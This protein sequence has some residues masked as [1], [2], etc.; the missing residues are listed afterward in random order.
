MKRKI[1]LKYIGIVDDWQGRDAHHCC[2]GFSTGEREKIWAIG[3]VK[4]FFFP[5]TL[6]LAEAM[7]EG[8]YDRGKVL[9]AGMGLG[10]EVFWCCRVFES[11][12]YFVY[13]NRCKEQYI[14]IVDDWQ[15]R[16]AHHCCLG[17]STGERRG[18]TKGVFSSSLPKKNNIELKGVS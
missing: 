1:R 17:F 5:A 16:D 12:S 13:S 2:L 6:T 18:K 4:V 9:F 15:G 14:G 10:M 8:I 11:C 3:D 7:V